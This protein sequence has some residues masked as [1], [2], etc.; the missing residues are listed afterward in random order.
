MCGIPDTSVADL[1]GE[2]TGRGREKAKAARATGKDGSN[3]VGKEKERILP[4]RS[5]LH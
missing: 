2:E 1:Y 3:P 4:G 5:L